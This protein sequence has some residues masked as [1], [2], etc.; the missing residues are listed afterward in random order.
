MPFARAAEK[1][2]EWGPLC[3]CAD[4]Q[5]VHRG[6]D[7][8]GPCSSVRCNYLVSASRCQTFLAKSTGPQN[9]WSDEK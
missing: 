2:P 1:T 7:H 8:H 5:L 3:V 4:P 6:S 9:T